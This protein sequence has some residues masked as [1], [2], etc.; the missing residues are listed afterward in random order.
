M[1]NVCIVGYGAIGPIH[2]AALQNIPE[3]N[4]YAICDVDVTKIDKCKEQYD[5]TKSYT[6]F[7]EMLKDE[8]IDSVHICTPHYL[9]YDMITAAIDSGKKVIAE[10]PVVMTEDELG[11]LMKFEGREQIAIVFQ[12]RLN[13]C[14]KELKKIVD[15]KKFGDVVCVRGIL[16]WNRD[17]KYYDSGAWRGKWK[18]EG[19]GVLINQAVH[20]LDLMGYLGGGFK[21]LKANMTNYTL[22]DVIEVEDTFSAVL[23]LKNGGTGVF[24]ATNAYEADSRYD[25]EVVFENG[26]AHYVDDKL[27]VNDELICHDTTVTGEKSYWGASHE[28]LIRNFYKNEIYYNINDAKNTMF[29]L[30]AMYNSARNNGEEVVIK[31]I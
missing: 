30:F 6:D 31:E 18:T 13:T 15:N 20:T 8:D 23:K 5:V 11:K 3:A 4:L 21:S 27:F 14:V 17:K 10:K 12:N 26:S 2:A 7:Y 16:T 9:H 25:I 22:Q 29:S 24:F 19:G 1:K 28:E